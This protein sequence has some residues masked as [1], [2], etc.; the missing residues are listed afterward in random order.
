M[1]DDY[2]PAPRPARRHSALAGPSRFA[3]ESGSGAGGSSGASALAPP[4]AAALP[5]L[6]PL[7]AVPLGVV[8]HPAVALERAGSPALNA[9]EQAS[10]QRAIVAGRGPGLPVGPD[11]RIVRPRPGSAWPTA[12]DLKDWDGDEPPVLE[13]KN[14]VPNHTHLRQNVWVSKPRPK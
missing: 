7:S 3:L 12:A 8:P 9:R 11:G 13:G 4:P 10:S 5:A 6:E 2:E 1:D 14:A